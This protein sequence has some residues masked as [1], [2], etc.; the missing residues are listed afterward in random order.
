MTATG[1]RTPILTPAALLLAGALVGGLSLPLPARCQGVAVQPGPRTS[2]PAGGE[3][4]ADSR[5]WSHG[6]DWD[7]WDDDWDSWDDFNWTLL[8]MQRESIAS[9]EEQAREAGRA[10]RRDEI[11]AA[12]QQSAAEREEYFDAIL[13]SSLA[14]LRAPQGAYYRKPGHVSTEAPAAGARPVEAGGMSFIYDQGVFWLQQGTA[15]LVVTAPFGAVVDALPPAA[16][17]VPAGGSRLWYSFGTFYAA[18]GDRFE[19]VRPPAGAVVVYLPD[20]YTQESAGGVTLY[21]FGE[22]VFKPVFRQGTLV[23]QVQ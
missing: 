14:A 1:A 15:W 2:A 12:R 19:V 9:Q 8:K 7:S 6:G 11:E 10:R 5:N 22:L 17:P 13:S 4:F 23:Y 3:R 18:Q 16:Y 20:G 21:R